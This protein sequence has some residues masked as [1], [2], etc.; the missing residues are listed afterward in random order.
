MTPIGGLPGNRPRRPISEKVIAADQVR[1]ERV[2]GRFVDATM[3]AIVPTEPIAVIIK[4]K[5]ISVNNFVELERFASKIDD[6]IPVLYSPTASLIEA[7]LFNETT[8]FESVHN[9]CFI[10]ISKVS[11]FLV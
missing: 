8:L 5:M 10:E 7:L 2:G 1:A 6:V 3:N 4:N 11:I 9:T